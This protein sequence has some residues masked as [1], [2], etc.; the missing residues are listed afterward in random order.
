[1]QTVFGI[2]LLPLLGGFLFLSRFNITFPKA[3][4]YDGYKLLFYSASVGIGAELILKI[5]K[6]FFILIN[7]ISPKISTAISAVFLRITESGLGLIHIDHQVFLNR[8]REAINNLNQI[9]NTR[10]ADDLY[11]FI[12]LFLLPWI[13]NR[14]FNLADSVEDTIINLGSELEKTLL[15]AQLSKQLIC[16]TLKNRKVYIGYVLEPT[17]QTSRLNTT[18]SY[19][20]ILPAFSGYRGN[21]NLKITITENYLPIINDLNYLKELNLSEE[22]FYITLSESEVIS[23]NKFDERIYE[24]FNPSYREDISAPEDNYLSDSD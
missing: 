20:V 21:E 4:R 2:P 14:F 18:N 24:A 16:V 19:L 22:D 10:D 12:I 1:M 5:T 3:I 11:T 17:L 7:T 13:L 9:I 8:V 23:V 6:I 15:D